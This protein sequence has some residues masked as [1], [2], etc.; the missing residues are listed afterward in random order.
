MYYLYVI[1]VWGNIFQTAFSAFCFIVCVKQSCIALHTHTPPWEFQASN[2]AEM[3]HLIHW[4]NGILP[5]NIINNLKAPPQS[6]SNLE[7]NSLRDKG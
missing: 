7:R 6:Y 2:E 5:E 4:F 1:N 3:G